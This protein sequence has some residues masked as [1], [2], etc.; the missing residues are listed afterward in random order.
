MMVGDSVLPIQEEKLDP[1]YVVHA[2]I[3]PTIAAGA[4]KSSSDENEEEE[5]ADPD[6]S[7][8]NARAARPEDGLLSLTELKDLF[9]KSG[10]PLKSAYDSGLRGYLES[11]NSSDKPTRTFGDRVPI[12][13][14][15]RGGYEPEW[16]S[17]TF[18]WKLVLGKPDWKRLTVLFSQ[19]N[20][21]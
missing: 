7:I 6:K 16:T 14:S 1:S 11:L 12:P 20:F 2:T 18:Y 4:N 3:D 21:S 8:T 5:G 13:S 19:N 15:R 10:P 9:S 17:Y